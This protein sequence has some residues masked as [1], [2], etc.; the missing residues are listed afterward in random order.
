MPTVTVGD[1]AMYYEVRGEG[2]PVVLIGGLGADISLYKALANDLARKYRV[3]VFDNRGVGR[4]SK[5]DSPY[6]SKR[7]ADDT[8]GLLDQVA[9]AIDAFLA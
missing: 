9:E 4:T 2:K 7:F 3:V 6:S 8:V 1:I 5:P